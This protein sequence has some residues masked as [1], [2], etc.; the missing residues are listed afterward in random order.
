MSHT[1]CS[2]QY[3]RSVGRFSRSMEASLAGLSAPRWATP[4][5]W[6]AKG[7]QETPG[8]PFIASSFR[9]AQLGQSQD[10]TPRAFLGFSPARRRCSPRAAHVSW[11][12]SPRGELLFVIE[13]AFKPAQMAVRCATPGLRC[14][15][16]IIIGPRGCHFSRGKGELTVCRL[17]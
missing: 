10:R 6:I 1:V 13:R 17:R 4:R 11:D 12:N 8:L 15:P 7:L 5:T 2:H 14:G 9:C 3:P 16:E